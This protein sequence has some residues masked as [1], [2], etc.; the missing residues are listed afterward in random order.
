MPAK[1]GRPPLGTTEGISL[2]L[3]IATGA[4]A[5]L[6]F[7]AISF[8]AQ[9]IATPIIFGIGIGIAVHIVLYGP[10]ESLKC[11]TEILSKAPHAIQMAIAKAPAILEQ[12]AHI[13]MR[14]TQRALK[15]IRNAGHT[16]PMTPFFQQAV[17]TIKPQKKQSVPIRV[18]KKI[19]S[20]VVWVAKKTVSAPFYAVRSLVAMVVTPVI[21][22][23]V[24]LA[25]LHIAARPDRS[26]EIARDL[27]VATPKALKSAI[28]YAPTAFGA[29]RN[30]S[31][32]AYQSS[33]QAL[34]NKVCQPS[35]PKHTLSTVVAGLATT[36]VQ[37]AKTYVSGPNQTNLG[38]IPCCEF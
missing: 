22:G 34:G 1:I 17:Q 2:G 23:A 31:Q 29:A 24:A 26:K 15:Y 18:I 32:R 16:L 10:K 3:I 33:L 6:A 20:K 30:L 14:L 21:Y 28:A 12:M 38:A 7:H 11:A 36:T 9:I 35:T 27:L 37:K 8:I 5:I 25:V 4:A 19:N 13:A